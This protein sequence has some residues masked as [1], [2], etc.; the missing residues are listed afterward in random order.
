ML[1]ELFGTDEFPALPADEQYFGDAQERRTRDDEARNLLRT[2]DDD[3]SA[4]GD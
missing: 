4:T 1:R 3:F 2:A